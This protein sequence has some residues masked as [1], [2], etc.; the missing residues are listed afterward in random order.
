MG[1]VGAKP[2][3]VT[4]RR[5]SVEPNETRTNLDIK[6]SETQYAPDELRRKKNQLE[7]AGSLIKAAAAAA[8]GPIVVVS[9]VP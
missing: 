4:T 3:S 8:T 7:P 2:Y 5:K 9:L 6:N 1:P